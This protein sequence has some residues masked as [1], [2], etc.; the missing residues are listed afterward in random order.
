LEERHCGG[1][2]AMLAEHHVD[3][4]AVAINGAIQI[5]PVRVHLDIYLPS[6]FPAAPIPRPLSSEQ[7]SLAREL[8]EAHVRLGGEVGA[9]A[10]N[11]FTPYL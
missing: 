8:A 1:H 10:I 2:V 11:W 4:C 3:Q 7:G 6:S 5:A 9:S